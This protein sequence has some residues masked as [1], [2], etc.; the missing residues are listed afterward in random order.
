MHRLRRAFPHVVLACKSVL[1]GVLPGRVSGPAHRTAA[2]LLVGRQRCFGDGGTTPTRFRG[3]RTTV[4]HRPPA[5]LTS[6]D[7]RP[8]ASGERTW[9]GVRPKLRPRSWSYRRPVRV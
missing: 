1:A 7:R 2:H 8:V 3:L 6:A 5:S 4:H 9:T